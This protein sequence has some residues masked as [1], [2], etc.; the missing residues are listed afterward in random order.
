MSGSLFRILLLL[1]AVCLAAPAWD[2]GPVACKHDACT[3]GVNAAKVLDT[4]PKYAASQ[5][6]S[7]GCA[8]GSEFYGGLCYRACEAG[9]YRTAVCTCKKS[10]GGIFDL[11]TDCSRFGSSSLPI[12][13]C[14]AGTEFYGGLCYSACPPGSVRTAV[15]TCEHSVK[16]RSNTHLY[17]VAGAVELLSRAG[18]GGDPIAAKV[19]QRMRASSCKSQWESGLWDADDGP[20]GEAGG[21]RGSHFYNGAG[22]DFWGTVTRVVTY[23]LPPGPGGAEQIGS[24]NGRTNARQ[25]LDAAG[26]VQTDAQC[27]QLGLALHYLSD[28]TQPMHAASF[29]AVDIPTNQHV[30]FEDYAGMLQGSFPSSSVTFDSRWK[31]SSADDVF[32]LAAVRANGFAPGLAALLKYDGTICTMTPEAGITYTGRCFLNDPAVNAKTGELIRDAYQSVAAYL[33]AAFRSIS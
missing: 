33:Y 20:L 19:V 14:P 9:W 31:G 29:S 8:A 18:G 7:D 1:G 17:I 27:Y 21:A 30:A 22:K 2:A 3:G 23:L 26:N 6:P 28:I 5:L 25:R 13:T 16:W 10:G 24:G 11:W 15:S 12:K 32:H 4:R